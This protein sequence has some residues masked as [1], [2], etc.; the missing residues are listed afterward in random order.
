[1]KSFLVSTIK[2]DFK[3]KGIYNSDVIHFQIWKREMP[4]PFPGFTS[5]FSIVSSTAE[6]NPEVR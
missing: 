4:L 6:S 5:L 3:S 1:M 2:I